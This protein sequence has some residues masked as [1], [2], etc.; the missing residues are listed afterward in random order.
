VLLNVLPLTVT[1]QRH[2][3]IVV[4]HHPAVILPSTLRHERSSLRL[5]ERNRRISGDLS[6]TLKMT[7]EEGFLDSGSR[8]CRPE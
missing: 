3:F 8:A 1:S 4:R 5:E 7:E 2:F 6:L